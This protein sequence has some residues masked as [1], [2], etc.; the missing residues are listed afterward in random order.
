MMNAKTTAGSTRFKVAIPVL[1]AQDLSVSLAFYA[2]LGFP[3]R[4][5]YDDYAAF[6]IGDAQ[7]GEIE[8]HLWQCDE[9]HIAENT[10]CRVEVEGIDALY[11]KCLSEGAVHSN[12]SLG[13]RPWG[14]REFVL[15][16]PAGNI[17]TFF[18][19]SPKVTN[20]AG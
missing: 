13:E 18:E 2:K 16:D 10:G 6:T 4:F 12:G 9:R 11:E 8:I 3:T 15:V 17:I 1:A 20:G 5:E 7:S 14:T 19:R